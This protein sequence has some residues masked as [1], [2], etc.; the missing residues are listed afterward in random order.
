MKRKRTKLIAAALALLLLLSGCSGA[1]NA[2]GETTSSGGGSYD[3]KNDSESYDMGWSA[4]MPSEPMEEWAEAESEGVKPDGVTAEGGAAVPETTQLPQKLVY[5]GNLT[6]ETLEFDAA[7]E[8]V[9][10]RVTEMGGFIE[11]SDR[12]GRTS[13]NGEGAP[14]LV[15]R[16]AS[17]TL[18]IPSDRFELFME[19]AGEMGNV[20]N[21]SRNLDNISQRFYDTQSRLEASRV[22][23][24]RLLELLE[25]AESMEDILVI[26]SRLSEVRYEIE[27]M[28]T[29]L[30]GWQAQVDYSTVHLY[31]EEVTRY[32][33]PAKQ[34][35]LERLVSAVVGSAESFSEGTFDL[36]ISFIYLFPWLVLVSVVVWLLRKRLPRVRLPRRRDRKGETEPQ[37]FPTVVDEPQPFPGDAEE[38]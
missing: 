33:P 38:E 31:I 8:A 19:S 25:Q 23:Y 26:E 36:L 32:T 29:T 5:T 4:E 37:S 17:Y 12:S 20:V 18:R 7:C 14:V 24:D 21:I 15:D 1:D 3:Y 16:Y 13:Y 35:P 9:S 22:Q 28:T 27:S 30:R 11:R 34:G 2:A 6:I 10:R